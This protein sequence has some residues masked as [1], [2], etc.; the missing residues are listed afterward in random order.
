MR[1][2]TVAELQRFVESQIHRLSEDLRDYKN[3]VNDEIQPL[4]TELE[5]RRNAR[6]EASS[7][8]EDFVQLV[9]RDVALTCPDCPST[10]MLCEK[11]RI[12]PVD[13]LREGAEKA[14]AENHARIEDLGRQVS[15]IEDGVGKLLASIADARKEVEDLLENLEEAKAARHEPEDDPPFKPCTHPPDRRSVKVR[16]RQ[17]C[18]ICGAKL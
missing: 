9:L 12:I 8:T 17:T 18:M 3:R 7:S 15:E 1:K 5:I 14:F 2:M 10:S 4:R 11:H 16:G 13:A 6:I